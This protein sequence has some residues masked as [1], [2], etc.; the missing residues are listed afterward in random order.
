[1]GPGVL[2]LAAIAVGLWAASHNEPKAAERAV[3]VPGLTVQDVVA[4]FVAAQ[5]SSAS[6]LLSLAASVP[7][8]TYGGALQSVASLIAAKNLPAGTS[9][10]SGALVSLVTMLYNFTQQ[11]ELLQLYAQALQQVGQTDFASKFLQRAVDIQRANTRTV[12]TTQR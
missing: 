10:M 6:T 11:P 12:V 3:K 1:M 9:T 5:N 7:G 2:V 4:G 8:T